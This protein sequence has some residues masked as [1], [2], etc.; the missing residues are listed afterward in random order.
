M[1]INDTQYHIFYNW[2]K[3]GYFMKNLW[4]ESIKPFELEGATV[5]VFTYEENGIKV[6]GFDSS[7]CVPPEPMVNAMLA[8]NHLKDENTKVVMVN[9]TNPVGLLAKIGKDFHI[10]TENLDK[11][12][13]RLTF[14]Y[15]AG[16]KPDLSDPSCAG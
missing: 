15:K 10:E 12:L 13:V 9:H 5:P 11:N 14:T 1:C 2:S 8:L 3:K 6:I 4:P 16:A 7:T